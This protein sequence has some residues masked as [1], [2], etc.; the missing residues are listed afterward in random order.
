[1]AKK[2]YRDSK[3]RFISY[4]TYLKHKP[5]TSTKKPKP[6]SKPKTS[7]KKPK[8]SS[9]PKTSTKKPKPSSKP[10]TSTRKP[11]PSSK[12]KTST[13]KPKPSS[14]PKTSTKKPKPSSKP[15]TSTK[16][17][18]PSSKPK[19]STKK[20]KPSSKP[21]TSTKKPKLTTWFDSTILAV[22]V[23]KLGEITD[24]LLKSENVVSLNGNSKLYDMDKILDSLVRIMGRA[25][26]K[27]AIRIVLKSN[28]NLTVRIIRD[29]AEELK[30]E[31]E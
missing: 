22:E 24:N 14:K 29:G 18:K 27:D 21:K 12:P 6:S 1:M 9:K 2:L 31:T 30:K 20:P 10:K 11:K 28:G 13:K 3:G 16:K 15:K 25:T 8:P 4:T 7:T 19:T 23:K 17:P 26:S 5:K